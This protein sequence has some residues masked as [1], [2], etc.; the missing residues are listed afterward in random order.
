VQI[1]RFK[2]NRYE[3]HLD[4]GKQFDLIVGTSTGAIVGVALAA[5]ITLERII[6]FYRNNSKNI[7]Q[8]SAPLQTGS[9]WGGAKKIL[10]ALQNLNSPANDSHSLQ[11]ILT[12]V[13][14]TEMLGELYQ[15]RNIALCIP[16][17]DAEAQKGWVFKTP[18]LL[19]YTRDKYYKLVDVCL[20]STAAPI[21]FPLHAVKSPDTPSVSHK[22]V[23]GGLW[24]N[25]PIMVGLVEALE[26]AKPN[27]QI[28]I[29]SVGTGTD[30][31]SQSK[32]LSSVDLKRGVLGWTGGVGIVEMSLQAQAS[33]I[34]YYANRLAAATG[35]IKL[36]RLK[37][38]VLSSIEIPHFAI[39]A[40]DNK[41]LD[42]LENVAHKAATL[43]LS[44]LTNNR[45][46]NPEIEMVLDIFS[47]INRLKES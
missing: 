17:I 33:T 32:P 39:D 37:D 11:Q 8:R 45:S 6:E 35:R 38:P 10:W 31:I 22:F 19:R 15:R 4:F 1:A 34:T 42:L 43:N 3:S 36:Y 27:Q 44:L 28:Q 2:G 25:N 41:S 29:L 14:G 23:D 18:H 40:A 16:T 30:N 24:A 9:L 12:E 26:I 5:G 7:F 46:P 47:N 20:A 21:Y 13:L